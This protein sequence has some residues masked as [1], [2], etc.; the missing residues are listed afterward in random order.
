VVILIVRKTEAEPGRERMLE[1]DVEILPGV[2]LAD[3]PAVATKPVADAF[4]RPA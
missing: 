1:L 3:C 4:E 2:A